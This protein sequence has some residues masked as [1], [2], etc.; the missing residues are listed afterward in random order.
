MIF[1]SVVIRNFRQYINEKIIISKPEGSKNFTIIQGVNGAGKTNIL[2]AITWCLYGKEMHSGEKYRGLPIVSMP[3]FQTLSP[4]ET[5][6]VE[7]EIHMLDEDLNTIIIRR[8]LAFRKSNDGELKFIPNPL[9]GS[10]D[11]SKLEMMR[12]IGKDMKDVSS[13]NYIINRLIPESLEEYFFFDGERLNDY[14]RETTGEKIGEEVLIISQIDLTEKTL[15]H[16]NEKRKEFLKGSKL[17]TEAE[18]IKETLAVYESSFEKYKEELKTKQKEKEEAEN[19]EKEYSEKLKTSSKADVKRLQ[20]DRENTDEFLERIEKD[21]KDKEKEKLDYLLSVG[22]S[23]LTYNPIV[24]TSEIIS[25]KETAGDIPTEYKR[26]FITKLILKG[27]CICGTDISKDNEFRKNVNQVLEHCSKISDIEDELIREDARLK[28]IIDEI[29]KFNKNITNLNNKIKELEEI[30]KEKNDHLNEISEELKKC[31]DIELIGVWEGKR[32]EYAKIKTDLLIEIGKIKANSERADRDIE[33]LKKDLEEEL[34]KEKKY[35]GL[36]KI[37]NFCDLC[38]E[39]LKTIKTEIMEETRKE[40][41]EKTKNQFFNLIWK[42]ENYKDVKI[43]KDYVMSVI[44]QSGMEGI[45]TLSAGE[46]QVLALSFMAA[47]N[48]VSGFEV[49]IIIDTPLGRL[50]RE[51]KINI[52]KN[53]PNF[54]K[55]KQ[56]ILLVTEE[57]YT[58]EVRDRLFDRIGKEYRIDFKESKEGGR[59][60]VVPYG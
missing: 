44:H 28:I 16:L 48:S 24:Q 43:N 30:K 18:K 22:P 34:E 58:P 2:N 37:L 11:G 54:L 56:V 39:G 33:K 9:G 52:A 31:G 8:T 21:L 12:Q 40:I 50:S 29:N 27:K 3:T 42:R 13:P 59:A 60:M 38:L 51:P 46:R 17:S 25:G 19:L 6:Q 41:E 15:K 4:D 47:L 45:D 35:E 5:S 14:F 20:T 10:P 49:P 57:E 26:N 55:N 1:E 7:V 32:E 53:L 36:R 23:I